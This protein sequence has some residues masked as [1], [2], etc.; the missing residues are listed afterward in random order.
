[1]A[2]ELRVKADYS[3]FERGKAVGNNKE[4]RQLET[5]EGATGIRPG[6]KNALKL[7]LGVRTKGRGYGKTM[8]EGE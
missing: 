7:L 4:G 6:E 2:K 1:V 5:R 8:G 3:I